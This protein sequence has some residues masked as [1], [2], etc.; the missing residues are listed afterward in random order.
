LI[1][2]EVNIKLGIKSALAFA[3]LIDVTRKHALSQ[4]AGFEQMPVGYTAEQILSLLLEA[5]DSHWITA[6]IKK[7]RQ[8]S[9][10]LI[11]DEFEA[12]VTAVLEANYAEKGDY[13]YRLIRE[14][15]DLAANFLII[16]NVI[17]LR[18]GQEINGHVVTGEALFL[19]A[20]LHDVLMLDVEAETVEFNTVSTHIMMEYL[21]SMMLKAP[22]FK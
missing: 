18:C 17:N 4:Y 19:Q 5:K 7:L 11:A 15:Y 8:P 2:A 3:A 12:A 6:Y 1:N 10:I 21:Q 13:G 20:G 14:A 22:E 9:S 16:E